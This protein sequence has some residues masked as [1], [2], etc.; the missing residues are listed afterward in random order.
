MKTLP[1]SA[2][3]GRAAGLRGAGRDQAVG[4]DLEAAAGVH[5]HEAAGAVGV[6][7]PGPA[8]K[9]AW[10]KSALCWSPATPPIGDRRAEQVGASCWPKTWL[11]GCTSGS[12]ARGTSSAASSSS[13]QAPSRHVEEQRARGVARRRWR[14]PRRRVAAVAPPVSSHISQLSTVPKAS[15]PRCGRGARAG[16]V[17]EQP[18]ELGAREVG[19]EDEAGAL[20]EERLEA[21]LL[22]RLAR[23]RGAPVLPDDGVADRLAG[24]RGPRRASS[25]AGW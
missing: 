14:G 16:D 13:L 17:V 20:A 21:A 25:R 3:C 18:G 2:N 24:A 9:H 8:R 22:Q 19:V 7:R 10:P 4:R 1:S 5:Q 15:S 12:T 6:L 11:D 23:R